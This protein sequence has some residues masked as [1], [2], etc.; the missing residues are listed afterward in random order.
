MTTS[1][2][3]VSERN[4]A[5]SFETIDADAVSAEE[6]AAS[7]ELYN[8]LR[9]R[10]HS[11]S[12]EHQAPKPDEAFDSAVR[13][14]AQTRSA[15]IRAS[16]EAS[17]NATSRAGLDSVRKGADIPIWLYAAWAIAIAAAITALALLW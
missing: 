1:K 17:N 5:A 13:K 9:K 16:L 10:R 3:S 14:A 6:N 7:K 8:A 12:G 15:E 2:P 4:R 11:I